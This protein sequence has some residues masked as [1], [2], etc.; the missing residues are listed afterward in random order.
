MAPHIRAW[1]PVEPGKRVRARER[2]GRSRPFYRQRARLTNR[3]K[4]YERAVRQF[5]QIRDW[6]TT[7]INRSLNRIVLLRR[8]AHPTVKTPAE[9]LRAHRA[10]QLYTGMGRHRA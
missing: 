4:C 6:L 5:R 1:K 8:S 2:A 9:A 10:G 3:S 7:E